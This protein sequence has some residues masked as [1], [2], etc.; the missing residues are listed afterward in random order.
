MVIKGLYFVADADNSIAKEELA[1]IHEA[2]K[3]LG[4]KRDRLE[5]LLAELA[6]E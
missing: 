4:L 3:L 6:K 2:G 1:K 5:A